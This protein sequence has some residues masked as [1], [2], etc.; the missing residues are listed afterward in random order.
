[1]ELA[2]PSPWADNSQMHY[3]ECSA[4]LRDY[5]TQ[6]GKIQHFEDSIKNEFLL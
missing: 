6:S 1:M 2:Y 3:T 5:V 4:A